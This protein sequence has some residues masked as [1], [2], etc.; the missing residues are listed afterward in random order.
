VKKL[1]ELADHRECWQTTEDDGLPYNLMVSCS[2]V[3]RGR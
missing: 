2:S 3:S 1:A